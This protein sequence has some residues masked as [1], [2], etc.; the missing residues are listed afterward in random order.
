MDFEILYFLNGIHNDVL[1]KIMIGFTYLAEKGIFW[2]ALSI[3]FMIFKKTRKMRN[4]YGNFN[5][6]SV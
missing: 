3:I 1:D 5:A 2:I 6:C 4:I